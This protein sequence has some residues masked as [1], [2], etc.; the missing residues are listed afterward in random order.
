[1]GEVPE[2]W[3]KAIFKKHQKEYPGNYRPVRLTP[4]PGK[5]MEQIILE[6]ISR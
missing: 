5:V 4:T 3:R 2:G 6:N 1:L